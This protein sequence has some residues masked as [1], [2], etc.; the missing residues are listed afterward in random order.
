M[1]PVLAPFEVCHLQAPGVVTCRVVSRSYESYRKYAALLNG[2]TAAPVGL[3][4]CDE[5]HRLKSSGGSKTMEVPHFL[6]S[7]YLSLSIS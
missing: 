6:F 3:M 4:V 2:P 7:F 1:R 5:G